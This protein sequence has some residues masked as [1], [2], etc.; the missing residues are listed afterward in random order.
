VAVA[1]AGRIR[2]VHADMLLEQLRHETVRGPAH[3]DGE[4][5]DLGAIGVAL[6]SALDRR[7]LATQA[8]HAL[9]QLRLLMNGVCHGPH[10][11]Q[12]TV[13]WYIPPGVYV[14][15]YTICVAAR[16]VCRCWACRHC[17]RSRLPR[18]RK[19]PRPRRSALRCT[20]RRPTWNRRPRTFML[21]T[22]APTA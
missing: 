12:I 17:S 15:R 19:R 7:D 14:K 22:E 10:S 1:L 8:A 3:R 9:H 13:L 20:G 21:P 2:H 5:H 16:F 4:L 18:P 6:K 11:C